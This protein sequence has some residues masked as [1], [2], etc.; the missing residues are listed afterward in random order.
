MPA[1]VPHPDQ[2]PRKP[3]VAPE[4]SDGIRS[5]AAGP[6][7]DG[8]HRHR[9]K[10]VR[11]AESGWSGPVSRFRWLSWNRAGRTPPSG[12]WQTKIRCGCGSVSCASGLG[13]GGLEPG[14]AGADPKCGLVGGGNDV[15]HGVDAAP[16]VGQAVADEASA[17]GG[18]GRNSCTRET[19]PVVFR[20]AH[21][22]HP[23][24]RRVRRAPVLDVSR[25]VADAQEQGWDVCQGLTPTAADWLD[26]DL[27]RPEE[28]AI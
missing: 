7:R 28:S 8:V 3:F 5:V 17:A 21:P 11:R 26:N 10:P 23:V 2:P 20:H 14:L 13:S 27:N 24:P 16:V 22:P 12:V 19:N 4:A 1:A 18:F 6:G 9:G 15:L 25:A